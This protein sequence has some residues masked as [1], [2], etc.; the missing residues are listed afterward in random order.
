MELHRLRLFDYVPRGIRSLAIDSTNQRLAVARLDASIEIWGPATGTL[1]DCRGHWR[2]EL[3]IPGIEDEEITVVAWCCSELVTAGM[4]GQISAWNTKKLIP[5]LTLD[6]FCGAVWAMRA[7]HSDSQLAVGGEDGSIR[8][9]DVADTERGL[10]Y[11]CTF[12]KQE[13]RIL[14]L[15]W[16]P[17]DQYIYTG[18]AE[19]VVYKWDVD[20]RQ[21]V[22]RITLDEY[23]EKSTRVWSLCCP[24][25]STLVSGDSLGKVQFWNS[26][27]GTLQHSFH[28]HQADVLSLVADGRGRVF[29]S[30]IDSKVIELQ[31]I[32]EGGDKWVHSGSARRHTH[33]VQAMVMCGNCLVSGGLDTRLVVYDCRHG[34]SRDASI[35]IPSYPHQ[36]LVSVASEANLVLFQ[37]STF[38]HVWMLGRA[39]KAEMESQVDFEM[40][41]APPQGVTCDADEF[42]LDKDPCLL[43]EMKSSS[44]HHLLCSVISPDGK[45]VAFS[46]CCSL[47]AYVLSGMKRPLK[48]KR[49]QPPSAAK[50]PTHLLPA[51]HLA[52]TP[53]SD[54]LIAA[55][56]DATVRI[57]KVNTEEVSVISSIDDAPVDMLAVS[58]CGRF[59]ATSD[60]HCRLH[61][62]SLESFDLVSSIPVGTSLH[63]AIAFQPTKPVVVICTGDSGIQL[64]DFKRGKFTRWSREVKQAGLPDQWRSHPAKVTGVSFLQSDSPDKMFLWNHCFVC[65][66]DLTKPLPHAKSD[67][68][69]KALKHSDGQVVKKFKGIVESGSF[70]VFQQMEGVVFFGAM[71]DGRC[72][73]IERPWSDIEKRLPPVLF[74]VRYGT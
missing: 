52:F 2:Q 64:F 11:R 39:K 32:R 33:D 47:R 53:N 27:H 36:R 14:S 22:T 44:R 69:G 48:K 46:D 58:S 10:D 72:L 6:S 41:A 25:N 30:G 20:Q 12:P 19:S 18:S 29:A 31:R 57:L 40:L 8:L 42:V 45:F 61:V 71:E 73:T 15:A 65:V 1:E 51:Q 13:S 26:S 67:L 43:L 55:G 37:Y 68:F 54:S 63:T 70:K 59:F 7:N 3:V 74:R 38:L 23:K 60:L 28:L 4:N 17:D 49:K 50:I 21:C 16:Q 35:S 56:M 24:S 9:F 5:K 62:Y 34:L 66:V